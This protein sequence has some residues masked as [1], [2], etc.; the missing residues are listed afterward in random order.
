LASQPQTALVVVDMLNP[1]EHD[2]ADMLTASV[3]NAVAPI[4]SLISRAREDEI[5]IVYVNDNYGD[6]SSSAEKIVERALDGGRP[7]LVE[8]LAPPE[9]VRFVIKPRHT[10]FYETPLDYLLYREGIERIVLTGQVTEQCIL[11]SALDAYVR[12]LRVA[13]PVDAVAHIHEQL[14]RSAVEMMETNMHAE[15]TTAADCPLRP[16][17][18]SGRAR[19]QPLRRW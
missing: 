9:G 6:W 1:Y 8:P 14:A 10:I 15:I 13:I 5:T 4:R 3:E 16:A 18:D 19:R 17:T 2:D 12:H 11:Y 7:D